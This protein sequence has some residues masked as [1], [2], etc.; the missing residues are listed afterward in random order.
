VWATCSAD[1]DDCGFQNVTTQLIAREQISSTGDNEI[2]TGAT[3]FDA[4]YIFYN[5]ITN[6]FTMS[7]T[8]SGGAEFDTLTS[9]SL[10]ANGGGIPVIYGG[11]DPDDPST[12]SFL[13]QADSTNDV[14]AD[15]VF[16]FSF[17]INDAKGVLS[18]SGGKIELSTSPTMMIG[19]TESPVDTGTPASQK[20]VEIATAVNGM[21]VEIRKGWSNYYINVSTGSVEF[22]NSSNQVGSIAR[23]GY[24]SFTENS[25]ALDVDFLNW[26]FDATGATLVVSNA[27][28]NASLSTGDGKVFIDVGGNGLY[29]EPSSTTVFDKDF[30]AT[31]VTESEATWELSATAIAALASKCT[32]SD[33]HITILAGGEKI[34]GLDESPFAKLT[35]EYKNSKPFYTGNLLLIEPNG[36]ICTLYN[37]PPATGARDTLSVR[38]TNMSNKED[39][40]VLGTLRDKDNNILFEDQ[41]LIETI[42]PRQT[43]RIDAAELEAIAG[44]TWSGRAILTLSS[45]IPN[46]Q[47]EVLG[48]ARSGSNGP[49]MNISVGVTGD[50]C[51]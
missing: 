43:K 37:I 33:C 30:A 35:I 11:V 16:S 47:M 28:F 49:L 48:L 34:K 51:D 13:V 21:D 17:S 26:A 15:T 29:D 6:P 10:I 14:S 45:D 9:V 25:N 40:V 36:T 12:V 46:G 50:G 5:N 8:L 41:P 31:T 39:A 32:V 7:F 27:P 24:I 3:K 18:T 22:V 44:Q 38:V 1:T 20:K 42:L 4:S 23:L 2:G 19:A